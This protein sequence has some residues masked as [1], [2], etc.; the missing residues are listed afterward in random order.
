MKT[1]ENARLA[2]ASQLCSNS[3]TSKRPIPA[4]RGCCCD[5]GFPAFSFLAMRKPKLAP[6]SRRSHQVPEQHSRSSHVPDA[7]IG[8]RQDQVSEDICENE[9]DR[10]HQDAGLYDGEITAVDAADEISA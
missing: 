8:V 5:R 9:R 6:N 7:G 2:I 3:R 10:N 4:L 1:R